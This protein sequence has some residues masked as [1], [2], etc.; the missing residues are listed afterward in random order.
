MDSKSCP[1]CGARW[2]EGQLYWATGKPGNEED[3]AGLVCLHYGDDRCI[4]PKKNVETGDSWEKRRKFLDGIGETL[5]G[6]NEN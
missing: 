2:L 4:N 6:I 5:E 1:K 3:L